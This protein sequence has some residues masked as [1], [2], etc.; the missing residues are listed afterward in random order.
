M[1]VLEIKAF[2]PSRNFNQSREFYQELGFS[3][4][5][6]NA[7]VCEMEIEGCRFL[8]QNFFNEELAGNLMMTMVV[9]NLDGWW[10]LINRIDL[11]GRYGLKIARAPERQPWGIRVLYLS[12]PGGVLWH[13]AEQPRSSPGE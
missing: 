11:A 4:N 12:D 5:W 7:E 1:A 2:V 6:S 8:L 10:Y 13:I 3:E 9:D